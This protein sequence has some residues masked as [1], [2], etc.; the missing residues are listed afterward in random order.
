MVDCAQDLQER[1][2]Q[3]APGTPSTS[4][5]GGD[6][7]TRTS[8][9]DAGTPSTSH[10]GEDPCTQ[11]NTSRAASPRGR[12]RHSTSAHPCA[13]APPA[14]SPDPVGGSAARR[15]AATATRWQPGNTAEKKQ[16][17]R[18]SRP[19]PHLISV[20]RFSPPENGIT[21]S[22]LPGMRANL[23]ARSRLPQAIWQGECER[24]GG[25]SRFTRQR[26]PSAALPRPGVSRMMV[27]QPGPLFLHRGVQHAALVRSSCVDEHVVR[28]L[29]DM[30][31]AG[32]DAI[33]HN[34]YVRPPG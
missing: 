27:F 20:S 11:T 28:Y 29:T 17:E 24:L 5:P 22:R 16:P 25:C 33:C 26:L 12:T 21:R 15:P 32:T 14:A 9:S 10:P 19:P 4:H 6:R 13:P 8:T 2:S 3:P 30:Q 1:A 7:G 31:S 34:G 23:F 18:M